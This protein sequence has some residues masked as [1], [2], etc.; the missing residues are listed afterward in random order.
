[1]SSN[2]STGC[3]AGAS[4]AAAAPTTV[5]FGYSAAED[6]IV[7]VCTQGET[8][9]TVLLTRRLVRQVIAR[10]AQMLEQSSPIAGRA[11]AAMRAEVV[12]F[13]HESAVA[14]LSI[15]TGPAPTKALGAAASRASGLLVARVDL[16][17][18]PQGYVLVLSD[19][20]SRNVTLRLQWQDLHRLLGALHQ[21]A[22]GAQWDLAEAAPWLAPP[23]ASSAATA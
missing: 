23:A 18:Q 4:T 14:Q 16:T 15:G 7:G 9:A 19:G 13:E 5:S 22:R 10:L 1:M 21:Q 8:S 12:Q 11:P 17:T 2:D 6:R 3:A 20:G